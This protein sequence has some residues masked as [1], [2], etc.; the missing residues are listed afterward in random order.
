[1][2]PFE[3]LFFESIPSSLRISRADPLP[4]PI[5]FRGHIQ[6]PARL[7]YSLPFGPSGA[8]HGLK[9]HGLHGLRFPRAPRSPH[10]S[11]NGALKELLLAATRD[12]APYVS[13][14]PIPM[15]IGSG[16]DLPII[17]R[18]FGHEPPPSPPI[19]PI[20][21]DLHRHRSPILAIHGPPR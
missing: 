6:V 21:V 18:R 13:G 14:R 2:S 7:S 10:P 20:K 4:I 17:P 19:P 16:L 8:L 1:M 11:N 5:T 3:T 12:H 15:A 9:V